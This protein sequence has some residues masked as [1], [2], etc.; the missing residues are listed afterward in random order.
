[1]KL[2]SYPCIPT[3]MHRGGIQ[4]FGNAL[5]TI[6]SVVLLPWEVSCL[7]QQCRN[8]TFFSCSCVVCSL[9]V[10]EDQQ[11]YREIEIWQVIELVF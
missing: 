3:V 8:P 5:S 4:E 11:Y 7:N 6:F 9:F 2:F 1:M 10:F